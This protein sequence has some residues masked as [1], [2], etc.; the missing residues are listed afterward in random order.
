MAWNLLLENPENQGKEWVEERKA[1][2]R[3]VERFQ[4]NVERPTLNVEE[5][6][7]TRGGTPRA[8]TGAGRGQPRVEENLKSKI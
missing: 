3:K 4:S 6:R 5:K 8:R 7:K 1:G 2:S